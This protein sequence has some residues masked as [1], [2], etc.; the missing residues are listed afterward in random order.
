[1]LARAHPEKVQDG[2]QGNDIDQ[3]VHGAPGGGSQGAYRSVERS[4]RQC[5]QHQ[6]SRKPHQDE[7]TL[8]NVLANVVKLEAHIE[9]AVGQQV[10]ADIEKHEQPQ[11]AAIAGQRGHLEDG[12]RGR[13]AEH[14]TQG[15]QRPVPRSPHQRLRRVGPQ[16][17][18]YSTGQQPACRQQGDRKYDRFAPSRQQPLLNDVSHALTQ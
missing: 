3:T 10:Q 14:Q 18:Q 5:A 17:V 13:H 4:Q 6:E 1:M 12:A 8:S 15:T 11:H 2:Q 7:R 16:L 9:P